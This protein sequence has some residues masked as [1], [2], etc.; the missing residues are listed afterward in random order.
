M[1]LKA[2]PGD[3]SV[4]PPLV[5]T[6]DSVDLPVAGGQEVRPTESVETVQSWPVGLGLAWPPECITPPWILLLLSLDF[7][8]NG[9]GSEEGTGG[10]GTGGR[11]LY[12]FGTLG[13]ERGER[14]RS[15]T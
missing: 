12:I 14:K 15:G 9:G 1:L 10:G 2:R 3:T 5:G 4:T 7:G 13:G 6:N 8:G 11:G